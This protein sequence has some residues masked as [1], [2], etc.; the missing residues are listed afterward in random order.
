[1]K[2]IEELK[3]NLSQ[4][5]IALYYEDGTIKD[6]NRIMDEL[7]QIISVLPPELVGAIIANLSGLRAEESEFL[8]R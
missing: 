5:G 1:M 3:I 4:A 7:A 8:N 2:A 6:T